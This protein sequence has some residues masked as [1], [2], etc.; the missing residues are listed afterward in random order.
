M[1]DVLHLAVDAPNSSVVIYITEHILMERSGSHWLAMHKIRTWI[2]ILVETRD[3]SYSI[4]VD[5]AGVNEK[6][7]QTAMETKR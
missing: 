3:H 6:I 1:I 4:I 7:I 2:L 5:F